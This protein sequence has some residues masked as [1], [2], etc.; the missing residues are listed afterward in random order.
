MHFLSLKQIINYFL[1]FTGFYKHILMIDMTSYGGKEGGL[2]LDSEQDVIGMILP[3]L[4]FVG[5]NSTYFSFAVSATTVLELAG[6]RL[7]KKFGAKKEE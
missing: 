2:V 6:L 5:V 7:D 4:S 1:I 3:P